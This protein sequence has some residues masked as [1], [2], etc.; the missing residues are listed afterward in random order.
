MQQ[1]DVGEESVAE[2]AAATNGEGHAGA[3]AD[4]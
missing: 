1:I 2:A 3:D 4:E